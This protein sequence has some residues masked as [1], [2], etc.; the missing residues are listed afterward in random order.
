MF[1]HSWYGNV[2]ELF[3]V[4]ERALLVSDSDTITSMDIPDFPETGYKMTS[5]NESVENFEKSIIAKALKENNDN[6]LRTADVLGL[7][8]TSLIYKL[9]K[10][11]FL[12]NDE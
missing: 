2:R 11:G 5:L 3:H 8:R 12:A 1:S 10:Y 9:K 7:S 4:L 6:Q